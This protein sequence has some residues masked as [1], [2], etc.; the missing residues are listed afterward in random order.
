MIREKDGTRR[1]KKN[2][3]A[4]FRQG[5]GTEGPVYVKVLFNPGDPVIWKQVAGMYQENP[6][7]VARVMKMI[8]KTQNP[9][10]DDLQV[11]L[12]TLMDSTEKDMVLRAARERARE[13]IQNGLVPGNIDQNFP[14]EDP[15]WD[16][17]TG[18]GMRRLKRYRD[19]VQIGVQ[20]A[21]PKTINWSK[22]YN[23]RQEK[24]ESHSA[25]LERLKEIAKKYTDLDVETEQAKAQLALIFLVQSQKDIQKKLQKLE[26]G[27]LRNMDRLLEIAWKVYNNRENES[28]R[29]QQQILL[30]V[31]QGRRN[32]GFRGRARGFARGRGVSIG[33]GRGDFSGNPGGRSGLNQCAYCKKEGHWKNECLFRRDRFS[34]NSFQN[35]EA[36]KAMVLGDFSS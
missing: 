29:R 11:I 34:G 9:D 31:I 20:S 26:G 28:T 19:W 15:Q 27:D 24:T 12:D 36:V 14:M 10:W 32:Q 6:D 30:A 22:L 25:F 21:M 16:Y 2:I 35:Q 7:K 17:N 33:R 5:V 23:I 8:I 18:E 3:I 1:Q 13:D 4:P